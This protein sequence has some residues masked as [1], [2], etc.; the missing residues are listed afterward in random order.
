M[1]D[2]LALVA[3]LFW[4]ASNVTI[5]IGLQR[6]GGKGADNGAF[7]SILLTALLAAAVWLGG[8]L[9]FRW[10]ELAGQ[11][12][13]WFAVAGVLTVFV[14]RVLL[15]SS[16]RWLGAIR[17]SS[18]KRLVPFFSVLLG[19]MVLDESL[20]RMLM[21]GMALIFGGFAVLVHE[22]LVRQR[23]PRPP[24]AAPLTPAAKFLANPGFFYGTVSAL[25][26]AAG[27][28]ARKYGV[29]YLPEPAFGA[30]LG[31]VVGALLFV[32]MGAFISNYRSAVHSTFFRFNPW[33]FAAGVAGSAGQVL[34]F[35]AI[36]YSTVSRAA[37]IVSTE[38]FLTIIL[39]VLTIRDHEKVT[40]SVIVAAVLGGL[41][42]LAIL[43]DQAAP[44][45]CAPPACRPAEPGR[46]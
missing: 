23:G 35:F 21:L 22:A 40:R 46:S 33:F 2:F 25:A 44:A 16:I 17:G 26:Y 1:G 41:G 39:T 12:I 27:N 6:Q 37:M 15:Y 30:M 45:A 32:L 3:A 38:V 18:L 4:A 36:D 28:V 34:F 19:V 9:H 43:A 10:T 20:S 42:T 7:L 13:V 29:M 8:G 31:S 24:E 14:G 11:G 5:G